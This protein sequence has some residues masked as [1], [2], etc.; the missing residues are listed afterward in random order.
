MW[1][2]DAPPQRLAVPVGNLGEA[3]DQRCD[4]AV[5]MEQ[6]QLAHLAEALGQRSSEPLHGDG[7]H[8]VARHK[9]HAAPQEHLAPRHETGHLCEGNLVEFQRVVA[10]DGNAALGG[11]EFGLQGLFLRLANLNYASVFA[12]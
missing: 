9:G 4:A 7:R 1:L 12:V 5:V 2:E 11:G 3:G 10:R 8:L 6:L